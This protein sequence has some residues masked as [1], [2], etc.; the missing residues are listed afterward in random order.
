MF[1]FKIVQGRCR[2]L[3]SPPTPRRSGVTLAASRREPWSPSAPRRPGVALAAGH[4]GSCGC[5]QCQEGHE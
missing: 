1:T 4:A 2:E 3:W 5:H